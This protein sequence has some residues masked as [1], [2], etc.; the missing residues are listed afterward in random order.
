MN[1]KESVNWLI[2][3]GIGFVLGLSTIWTVDQFQFSDLRKT[4]DSAIASY[5]LATA[6][7]EQLK[8]TIDG[9]KAK[10]GQLNTSINSGE[11]LSVGISSGL[12]NG[13]ETLSG[14]ESQL[15]S[16][17]NVLATLPKES[18]SKDK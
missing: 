8:T 13:I 5:R 11:N 2:F 7:S 10:S 15:R 14:V 18:G 17:R 12:G 4:A 16:I 6:Q 3:L 1:G 9:L